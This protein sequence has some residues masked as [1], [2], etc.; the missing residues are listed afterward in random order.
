MRQIS[1][2]KGRGL[3]PG[4]HFRVARV[5][6]FNSRYPFQGVNFTSIHVLSRARAFRENWFSNSGFVG[7]YIMS[8]TQNVQL[9]KGYYACYT[10]RFGCFGLRSLF[11]QVVSH[12]KY[13][14][15]SVYPS[16]ERFES[17]GHFTQLTLT[18]PF[19]LEC[20][21]RPF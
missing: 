18:C 6:G 20:S 12:H 16:S 10:L 9:V 19:V 17:R 13:V 15:L 2:A 11:V 8:S 21:N 3:D 5:V 4:R 1:C 7:Y 14:L